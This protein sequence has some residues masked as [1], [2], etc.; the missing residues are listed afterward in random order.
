MRRDSSAHLSAGL[1]IVVV[2][3]GPISAG[4]GIGPLL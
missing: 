4:V 3:G 1:L 2:K